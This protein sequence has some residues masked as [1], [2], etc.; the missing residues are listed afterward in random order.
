MSPAGGA[1]RP[2][3]FEK[4]RAARSIKGYFGVHDPDHIIGAPS[5]EMLF[6]APGYRTGEPG[7][8]TFD[9]FKRRWIPRSSP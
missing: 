8:R 4:H 5:W 9:L 1:A 7:C 2:G 6:L 3:G